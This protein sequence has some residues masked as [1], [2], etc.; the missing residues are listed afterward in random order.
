MALKY[1]VQNGEL[2]S[3]D[4]NSLRFYPRNPLTQMAIGKGY[5]GIVTGKCDVGTF[6]K[7]DKTYDLL[8]IYVLLADQSDKVVKLP[9][10]TKVQKGYIVTFDVEANSAGYH[11]ARNIT[12]NAPVAKP[13]FQGEITQP[14]VNGIV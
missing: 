6:E 2:E 13:I 9:M 4:L 11:E 8:L 10:T 5:K 3:I 14:L 1:K 7:G 12:L